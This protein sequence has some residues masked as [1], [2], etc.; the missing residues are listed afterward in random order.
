MSCKSVDRH[1]GTDPH[2]KI[3]VQFYPFIELYRYSENG[4]GIGLYSPRRYVEPLPGFFV[5]LMYLVF[6]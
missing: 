5:S 6:Y 4:V 3:C 2:P 1:G